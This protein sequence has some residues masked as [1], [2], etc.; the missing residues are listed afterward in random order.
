MTKEEA[1]KRGLRDASKGKGPLFRVC[2][3]TMSLVSTIDDPMSDEWDDEV[4]VAYM[5][6]YDDNIC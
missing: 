4:R 6:G 5:C 1:F 2:R 3:K